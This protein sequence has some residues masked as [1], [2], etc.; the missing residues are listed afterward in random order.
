M[1]TFGVDGMALTNTKLPSG[2]QEKL[3]QHIESL[4]ADRPHASS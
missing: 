4:A 2:D 3:A 1:S